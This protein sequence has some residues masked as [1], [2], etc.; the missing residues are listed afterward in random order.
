MQTL[1]QITGS[2]SSSQ[3]ECCFFERSDLD[4]IRV[5]DTIGKR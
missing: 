5:I 3:K 1:S 2:P 4:Y